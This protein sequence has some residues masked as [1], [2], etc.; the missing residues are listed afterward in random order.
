MAK[1]IHDIL[2]TVSRRYRATHCDGVDDLPRWYSRKLREGCREL[3]GRGW[4]SAADMAHDLDAEL[5]AEDAAGREDA[6]YRK[7]AAFA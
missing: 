6:H 3:D 2:C 5:D 7:V 4:R 1:I